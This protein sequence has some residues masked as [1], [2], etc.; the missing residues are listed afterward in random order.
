MA[1]AVVNYELSDKFCYISSK[2]TC[3]PENFPCSSFITNKWLINRGI[4]VWDFIM[5]RGIKIQRQKQDGEDK[6]LKKHKIGR[7][8]NVEK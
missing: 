2:N 8:Q 4:Y 3:V 5:A 1:A 7:I 6:R